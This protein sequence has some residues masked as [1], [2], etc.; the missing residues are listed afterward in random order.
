LLVTTQCKAHIRVPK[1]I[2]KVIWQNGLTDR[3]LLW[4]KAASTLLISVP[5]NLDLAPCLMR[6][7]LGQ[8]SLPFSSSVF[9]QCTGNLPANTDHSTSRIA[10]KHTNCVLE[11]FKASNDLQREIYLRTGIYSVFIRLCA[12]CLEILYCVVS[13]KLPHAWKQVLL[14]KKAAKRHVIFDLTQLVLP[15]HLVHSLID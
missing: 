3:E 13:L 9:A 11:T 1:Q 6:H 15:R 7:F 10:L 14:R 4:Q 2:F 12:L 8:T 5:S